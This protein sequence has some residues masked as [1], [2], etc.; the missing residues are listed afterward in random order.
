M[1]INTVQGENISNVVSQMRSALI[2]LKTTNNVHS[3]IVP[4]LL[5]VFQ[6]TSVDSFNAIFSSMKMLKRLQGITYTPEEILQ[7]AEASYL[8]LQED[9][10]W[11]GTQLP[12]STVKTTAV[13]FWNFND[14]GH[15][16]RYCPK[17]RNPSQFQWNRAEANEGGTG[18]R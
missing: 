10:K 16:S 7:Q 6:T 4:K 12:D 3:D 18:T 2:R 8:E 13:K 11:M 15:M 9:G 14:P 17:P 5:E 1:K